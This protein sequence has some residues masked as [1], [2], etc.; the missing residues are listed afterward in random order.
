MLSHSRIS[1]VVSDIIPLLTTLFKRQYRTGLL[2]SSSVP[3]WPIAS[4]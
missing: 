3:P 2:L 4:C 1:Y